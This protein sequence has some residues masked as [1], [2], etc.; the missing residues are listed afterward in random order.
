MKEYVTEDKP[1][2]GRYEP[3]TV[4]DRYESVEF[5]IDG[6]DC[7][8]QFRIWNILPESMC[9]LVKENSEILEMLRVGDI[10]PLKYYTADSFGPTIYLDTEIR[11]I[12][13]EEEGRFK[14]HYLI[15]LAIQGQ[16]TQTK[17]H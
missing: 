7:L 3:G 13:K 11:H 14:G 10:L 2:K 4:T 12:Q 6:L 1:L 15:G 16:Q 17:I 8:H 9:V 5:S